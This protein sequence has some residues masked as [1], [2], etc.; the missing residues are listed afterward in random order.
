[1][2]AH[3]EPGEERGAECGRLDHGRDLD[4][5]LP[6][7]GERLHER[8]VRAHAALDAQ[9]RDGEARVALGR[10]DQVDAAVRHAF[11]DPPP[12]WR[13][14]GNGPPGPR[15]SDGGRSP[16]RTRS[17]S[18]AV[19]KVILASPQCTQPWPRSDACWS[20][21]IPAMGG[22]PGR[23]VASPTIPDESTMVGSIDAG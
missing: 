12:E 9:T 16:P 1:P 3:G 13:T 22:A 11:E 19:P 10:L 14:A 15:A 5:P 7:V 8:R 17:S 2:R 23:A 4:D 6:G 20:P 18:A 21:A